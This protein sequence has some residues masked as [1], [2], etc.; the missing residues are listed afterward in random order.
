MLYVFPSSHLHRWAGWALTAHEGCT[1]CIELRER[2][3]DHTEDVLA[4]LCCQF[5]RQLLQLSLN[6]AGKGW[7][8]AKGEAYLHHC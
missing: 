6:E 2:V 1:L 8:D 3:F 7:G 4:Q 5:G